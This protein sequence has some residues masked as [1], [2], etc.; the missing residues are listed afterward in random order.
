MVLQV[1]CKQQ[2]RHA[3]QGR[4]ERGCCLRCGDPTHH[5]NDCRF[6]ETMRNYCRNK[7]YLQKVFC[8][9]TTKRKRVDKQVT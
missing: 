4:G 6:T 8:N 2:G 5:S 3:R 1:I 7:G 9:Q